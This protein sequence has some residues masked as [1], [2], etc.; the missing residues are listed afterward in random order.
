MS[1]KEATSVYVH[2]N[3]ALVFVTDGI[4]KPF[5]HAIDVRQAPQIVANRILREYSTATDDAVVLIACCM[6]ARTDAERA[7]RT[8]R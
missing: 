5:Q 3:D 2:P 6:S 8:D 4:D 1:D 7:V